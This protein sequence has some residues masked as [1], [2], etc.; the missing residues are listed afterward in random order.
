MMI[1]PIAVKAT[2][3]IIT[4]LAKRIVGYQK[5]NHGSKVKEGAYEDCEI[6]MY[7]DKACIIVDADEIVLLTSDT[8]ESCRFIEEKYRVKKMKTYYYYKIQFKDGQKSYVRMS[9]KY[10][11]AMENYL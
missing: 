8:I 4:V 6:D 11:D 2:Q 1:E 7:D 5:G 9:K 3:G 10:R